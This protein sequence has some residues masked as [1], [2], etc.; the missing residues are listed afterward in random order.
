VI[1][2]SFAWA[3]SANAL[4]FIA[5]SVILHRVHMHAEAEPR[6]HSKIWD[7]FVI[8]CQ[9]RRILIL[10]LMVAA[11]TVADDPILVLGPALAKQLHVPA[12]W[13]GWFIAALGAGTVLG[14]FR[15]ARHQPT[16]RLAAT[17]LASLAL[18]MLLFVYAPTMWFAIVAALGAGASCLIANSVTRAALAEHAGPRKTAAVMAVW[19]VA[20]AGS[21]PFAS[22]LDGALGSWI[23]PQWTGSILAFPALIPFLIIM[24]EPRF[25]FW[26]KSLHVGPSQTLAT[27]DAR[28]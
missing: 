5:F 11:V 9:D 14:S 17:A 24:L 2:I 16:I 7:G 28:S 8:A 21:K 22:L 26:V 12:A 18:F 1:G 6:Q 10:L 15:G 4:S 25:G 20:W 19:A 23:G 13:S 27:G 3:F